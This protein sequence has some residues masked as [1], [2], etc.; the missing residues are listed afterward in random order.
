VTRV[1]LED[2]GDRTTV[3]VTQGPH[4]DEMV[5]QATAG[6][7]SILENLDSLVKG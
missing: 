7:T 2:D 4:T 6:W 1:V 5:P 3:T